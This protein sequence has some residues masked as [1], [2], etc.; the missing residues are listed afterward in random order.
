MV[1]DGVVA[2]VERAGQP[3]RP[4]GAGGVAEAISDL[5]YRGIQ[6]VFEV[7]ESVGGPELALQLI[8]S[9]NFARTFQQQCQHLKRLSL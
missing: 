9:H 7:N 2:A 3:L 8:A 1:D 6:A 5:H 4:G